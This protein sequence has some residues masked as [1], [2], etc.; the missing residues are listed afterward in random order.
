MQVGHVVL[1]V[2]AVAFVV[3]VLRVL[4]RAGFPVR[5]SHRTKR[6]RAELVISSSEPFVIKHDWLDDRK[7]GC[8]DALKDK[9]KDSWN[10]DL[11]NDWTDDSNFR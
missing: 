4:G 2:L 11:K 6:E 5:L 10:N 8:A 9:S 7:D 3:F 1:G